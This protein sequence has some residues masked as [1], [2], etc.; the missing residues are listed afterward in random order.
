MLCCVAILLFAPLIL[1]AT[2][3][4][5]VKVTF[6]R[7]EGMAALDRIIKENGADINRMVRHQIKDASLFIST[8]SNAD[9]VRYRTDH[10]KKNVVMGDERDVTGGTVLKH[11]GADMG[12]V[13]GVVTNMEADTGSANR[14]IIF[15]LVTVGPPEH[16]CP[17][18]SSSPPMTSAPHIERTTTIYT[19]QFLSLVQVGAGVAY[20]PT[21]RFVP[22]VQGQWGNERVRIF[23]EAGHS[24]YHQDRTFSGEKLDVTYRYV[25]GGI[26]WR[27]IRYSQFDLIAAWQRSEVY[28]TYYG[29]YARKLEGP[30]FGIRLEVNEHLAVTGLWTPA[31]EQLRGRDKVEHDNGRFYLGLNV[32]TAVLGGGDEE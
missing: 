24:L 12:R 22:M 3:L 32:F 23:G 30:A 11:F 28:S 18:A 31:E 26:A 2:T 13:F 4:D 1:Q 10:I 9:G 16:K 15:R 27:A 6:G 14:Y 5:S 25:M 7:N 21:E 19:T 29:K 17:G 8:E 20:L